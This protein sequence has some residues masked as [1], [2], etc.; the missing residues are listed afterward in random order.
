MA[1]ASGLALLSNGCLNLGGR[2]SQRVEIGSLE[3][4]NFSGQ[5]V[6]VEVLQ[7]ETMRFADNYATTVAQAVDDYVGTDPSSDARIQA[8]KWKLSQATAA[9]IDAAGPNPVLNALDLVVLA[10]VSRMVM[11]DEVPRIFGEQ[12]ENL[13]ATQRKLETNAWLA[14]KGALKPEQQQELRNLIE[15]WRRRNPDIRYVGAIRLRQLAESVGRVPRAA[16]SGPNSIFR[17]VSLDPLA[18]LDPTAEAIAQTREWAERA[19]YYSQRMPTLL[20]WQIQ[21]LSLQL[22]AQPE[23]K[24]VLADSDRLTRSTA[25]FAQLADQMPKVI[26]E[27]RQAAI[28]QIFEGVA[29]ERTNLLADFASEQQNLRQLLTET[30]QTLNAGSEMADSV[31]DSVNSLDEFVRYVSP[32][33]TNPASISTNGRPFDVLDYGTAAGQIGM[34]AKDLH[35]L[36]SGVNQTTPELVLLQHQTAVEA[37]GLI[38][39]AFWLGL[40]LILVFLIGLALVGLFYRALGNKLSR[41]SAEASAQPRFPTLPKTKG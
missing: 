31:R 8:V 2:R 9:F 17:L 6:L 40:A 12:G 37:T 20:D 33:K 4:T 32:P 35:T 13:V 1:L 25:A 14:V 30:R 16:S 27:Q 10:T 23:I 39:R 34:M 5:P 15:E 18:G 26:N 41:A 24:Q 19:M 7:T 21:L 22:A 28:Q 38:N 36:L 29:V 11:E 3:V